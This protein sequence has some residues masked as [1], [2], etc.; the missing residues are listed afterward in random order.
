MI[1]HY[2]HFKAIPRGKE[3]QQIRFKSTR[4]AGQWVRWAVVD[5]DPGSGSG[6]RDAGWDLS[7]CGLGAA[8][9][10][11]H[12]TARYALWVRSRMLYLITQTD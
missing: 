2:F 3:L 11:V 5:P 10:A 1:W 6:S 7:L 12:L 8:A 9:A 4:P